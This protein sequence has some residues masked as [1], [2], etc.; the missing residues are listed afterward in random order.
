MASPINTFKSLAIE[1]TTTPNIFYTAPVDTTTIVLLAQAT[2]VGNSDAEIT[3]YTRKNNVNTELVKNFVI[4]VKD[5]ASLLQGKLVIEPGS[6]VGV[7][8]T[9]NNVLKLTLSILETR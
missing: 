2:N 8:G 1:V 3:F 7:V 4:P 5:A 9:A 6:S